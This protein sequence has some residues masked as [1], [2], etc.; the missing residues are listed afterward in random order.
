MDEEYCEKCERDFSDKVERY[1]GSELCEDC[2]EAEWERYND[3]QSE[4]WA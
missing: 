4:Y 2:A 3:R 1:Y